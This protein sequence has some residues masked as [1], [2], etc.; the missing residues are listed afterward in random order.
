VRQIEALLKSGTIGTVNHVRVEMDEDFIADATA[1]IGFKS[2]KAS[3][4]GAL[5]DFGVHPLS[6]IQVLFG[7]ITRVIC[8]QSKP[9]ATRPMKNGTP[10]AA[11]THDIADALLELGD[12]ISEMMALNRSAWGRKGRIALQIYGGGGARGG[13][14]G[15][16]GGRRRGAAGGPGE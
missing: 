9:Y 10:R 6:L 16:G 15:R 7:D 5:D 2:E 1:E 12:G 14:R 8:H 4:H 13:G 3:G 11:E